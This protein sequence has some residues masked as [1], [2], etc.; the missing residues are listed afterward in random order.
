MATMQAYRLTGWQQPAQFC[1]VEVPAP[2]RDAVLVKVAGVGLCHSDFIFMDSPAGALPYD[3]PFTLGHEITGWVEQ[4]GADVDDL[5]PGQA[6]AVAGIHSCGRCRFCL[7]GADNYC[8]HGWKGRG[9]GEDGG[10]ASYVVV[11]RR[12][13]VALPSL[14]P[15]RAAPLTDAGA[16]SYH[17]VK[18]VLPKLTAGSSAVVIGVGGLGSFAVQWLR[19]L[20]PARVVAVDVSAR[21]LDL[22]R[23]LGAHETVQS[24]RAVARRL[25]AVLGPDRA[26]G[27]FDFVGSDATAALA[28]G[29]ADTLGSVAIVGAAGGT[30]HV[31]WLGVP[32]ECEVFIP[33]AATIADLHE[34]VALA[35]QGEVRIEVERFAFDEAP[36]AYARFRAGD[37]RGRAVVV[38]NE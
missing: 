25:A 12:E 18:K 22:A 8:V 32:F 29:A 15:S 3:L 4:P 24:D 7:R 36:S 35:E 14:E 2:G 33:Q 34:V 5:A 13:L 28:L 38:P 11:P 6:V 1:E 20:S 17:A 31:K 16:T 23:E 9:Y 19:L 10:L 27:V 21:R 37:L 30:A 26:A